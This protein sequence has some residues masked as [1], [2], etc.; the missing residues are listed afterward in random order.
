MSKK[1]YYKERNR[2]FTPYEIKAMAIS[3]S[4][5]KKVYR[6]IDEIT[7]TEEFGRLDKPNLAWWQFPSVSEISTKQLRNP[8][9]NRQMIAL[10]LL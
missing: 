6:S 9:I 8:K 2:L 5:L 4:R 10:G 7:D 1:L 3:K